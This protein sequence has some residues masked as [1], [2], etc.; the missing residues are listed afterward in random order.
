V[1][2]LAQLLGATVAVQHV[3]TCPPQLLDRLDP[4]DLF[5]REVGAGRA[6]RRVFAQKHEWARRTTKAELR[7]E[8]GPVKQVVPISYMPS[9]ANDER[10]QCEFQYSDAT[11]RPARQW[12]ASIGEWA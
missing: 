10:T 1:I 6:A 5:A 2:S 7:K 3:K 11:V 4:L 8:A 12:R 9:R